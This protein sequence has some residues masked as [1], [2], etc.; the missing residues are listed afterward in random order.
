M[1]LLNAVILSE[2]KN[3]ETTQRSGSCACAQ[4]DCREAAYSWRE[5]ASGGLRAK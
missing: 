1:V 2:A 3:L 4:D 5:R